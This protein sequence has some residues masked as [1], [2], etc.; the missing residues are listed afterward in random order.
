[1]ALPEPTPAADQS[2]A[3][4]LSLY[5]HSA[6]RLRLIDEH[7]CA[8][9]KAELRDM[10]ERQRRDIV[11]RSEREQEAHRRLELALKLMRQRE[12]RGLP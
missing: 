8:A 4:R 6:A 10:D 1:M 7:T 9:L 11:V 5:L 2:D 12:R 3:L